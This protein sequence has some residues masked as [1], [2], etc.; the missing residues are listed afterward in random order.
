MSKM[1]NPLLAGV[2]HEG[3]AWLY[4]FFAFAASRGAFCVELAV[5]LE[6]L[7]LQ[8]VFGASFVQF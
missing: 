3:S 7:I 6:I 5:D 1:Y 4:R 8:L 2:E